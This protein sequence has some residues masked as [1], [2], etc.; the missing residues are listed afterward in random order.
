MSRTEKTAQ[1]VSAPQSEACPCP[2]TLA[3][4]LAHIQTLKLQW[5][6]LRVLN[7]IIVARVGESV[8]S[9]SPTAQAQHP[10]LLNHNQPPPPVSLPPTLFIGLE[11]GNPMKESGGC[12]GLFVL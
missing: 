12:F 3:A 10:F 5:T 1:W 8:G 11:K 9:F 7:V 4:L 6:E 2:P